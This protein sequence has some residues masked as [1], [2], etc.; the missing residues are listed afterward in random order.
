M[1]HAPLFVDRLARLSSVCLCVDHVDRV[2]VSNRRIDDDDAEG[3]RPAL[4]F[5]SFSSP[6]P[7]RPGKGHRGQGVRDGSAI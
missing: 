4:F 5:S 3:Q 1:P 6:P 2:D 7:W